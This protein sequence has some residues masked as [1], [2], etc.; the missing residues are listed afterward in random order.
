MSDNP[1]F[2]HT[3]IW[4]FSLFPKGSL[5]QDV[6]SKTS[7]TKISGVFDSVALAWE[8]GQKLINAGWVGIQMMPEAF[9][10]KV[11]DAAPQDV[12]TLAQNWITENQAALAEFFEERLQSYTVDADAVTAMKEAI[13]AYRLEHYVATVRT[14]MPELERFGRMVACGNGSLPSNQKEAVAAIQDYLGSFPISHFDPIES[15]TIYKIISDDLFAKCFTAA[16]AAQLTSGPNRH[17]ELHGL[18]SYGDLRGATQM[19]CVL[20]FLLR[21]VT[22][23]SAKANSVKR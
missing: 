23:A 8:A 10:W 18:K 16:D 9:L 15:L 20:D 3:G 19:L 6:S 22:V 1:Q 2:R 11:V 4:P 17:A 14:L 21:S 12:G 5:C 7:A 13:A